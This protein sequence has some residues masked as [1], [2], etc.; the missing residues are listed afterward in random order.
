[1]DGPEPSARRLTLAD[2]TGRWHLAR[3]IRD[4]ATG[5][6]MTLAG[7]AVLEPD[8]AGLR[9]REQGRLITGDGRALPAE[10]HYLWRTE[11]ALIALRFA[12]GRPFVR[13]DPREARPQATHDCAP[14]LY[15]GRWDFAAW[16]MWEQHW[17]VTGPRKDYSM[18]STYTPAPA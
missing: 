10:R 5:Q 9:Q 16:P 13:F 3:R 2:F 4:R 15:L 17:R 1:M 8:G 12:D 11:G 7:E 18:T 6:V 14:D